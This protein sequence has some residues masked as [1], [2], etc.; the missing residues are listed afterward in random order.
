MRS[1]RLDKIGVIADAITQR[2][3][4]AESIIGI[5]QGWKLVGAIKTAERKLAER[6]L[7]HGGQR[8][9]PWCVGNARAEQRS[10]ASLITKQTAGSAKIDPLMAMFDAVVL[11]ARNPEIR[12]PTYQMFFV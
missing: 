9:M 11:I 12:R 6:T 1:N 2:G 7:S 5:S 3:I 8:M 10:N 4:S